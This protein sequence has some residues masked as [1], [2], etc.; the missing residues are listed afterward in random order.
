MFGAL[1]VYAVAV[2]ALVAT[3]SATSQT[4]SAPKLAAGDTWTYRIT[5]LW[6]GR[7]RGESS[8]TVIGVLG[9]FVRLSTEVKSIASNGTGTLNPA[10][11]TTA[12]ANMDVVHVANGKTTTRVLFAW[13][14][15]AGKQW[16]YEYMVPITNSPP[17]TF[18]MTAE[19]SGWE[20]V[21]TAVGKFKA[22]KVVHTGTWDPGTGAATGKVTQTYWYAPEVKNYV[23]SQTEMTGA[24]G[25]PGLRELTEL[26]AVRAPQ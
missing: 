17:A 21:Q 3:P 24:D 1:S 25:A 20:D 8:M 18:R 2:A 5:D 26:I 10:F 15:S 16:N 6:S 22:L 12:R 11:E 7:A 19:A 13:P 9:E 23:R 4:V 14:L